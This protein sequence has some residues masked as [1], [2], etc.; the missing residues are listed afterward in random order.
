MIGY[1]FSVPFADS[2]DK[3]TI[4]VA[5]DPGGAVSFEEGYTPDYSADQETE[6][7]AKDVPRRQFNYFENVISGAMKE[8]QERGFKVY[9]VLVNYPVNS[10]TI[11]SDGGMYKS[12]E[13]NGPDTAIVDPVGDA[14]GIWDNITNNYAHFAEVQ[15]SGVD[16]GGITNNIWTTRDLNFEDTSGQTFA[17]L[18]AAG[19]IGLL[20]GNYIC[21]GSTPGR[22]VN[23]HTTQLYDI[24]GATQLVNG[25]SEQSPAI[26]ETATT[27]SFIIEPFTLTIDSIIE[28]QQKCST[29]GLINGQGISNGFPGKLERYSELGLWR[30]S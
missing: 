16:A 25:T 10:F 17:T 19:Q 3:T 21:M 22:I 23:M 1:Y 6:P 7:A 28:L 15:S 30:I 20:A 26:A 9:D 11:G 13:I 8:I 4:P 29:D 18:L 2:G 14:T 24:T 5:A 27:R 12:R